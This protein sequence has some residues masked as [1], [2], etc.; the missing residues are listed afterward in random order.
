M[1]NEFAATN[2]QTKVHRLESLLTEAKLLS[3]ELEADLVGLGKDLGLADT[4]AFRAIGKV[5][6]VQGT[7]ATAQA[8]TVASHRVLDAMRKQFNVRVTG[9]GAWKEDTIGQAEDGALKAVG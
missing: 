9:S 4:V 2:V 5:Q 3:N 7:I 1:K 6:E 8:A